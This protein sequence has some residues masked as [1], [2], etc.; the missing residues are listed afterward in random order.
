MERSVDS[1]RT[2]VGYTELV[3]RNP[4]FRNLWFG[5]IVSLFGDWFN[6]IASAA[7]ISVL[8]KSGLAVG[9]LFVVRMLAPFLVSPLAGVAADRYNRKLL[10]ILADLSRGVVVLGFLLVRDPQHAWLLYTLTAIQ[11]A[12]SGFFFPARNAI[13]PDIVSRRELGAANAL[14]SATWSVMLAVGA[15]L[16]GVVAGEWG[17]Y[18]AFII[19]SA[20][21]FISA[22]FISRIRYQHDAALSE[23][24]KSVR[25]ALTQYFN[26]LRYLK[27]HFDILSISLQKA[28][29][30]LAVNGAFQVIQVVLAE[31]IFVIGEGGGT[32]LGLLYAV[33]GVGTGI[34]PIIARRFTGDRDQPL[35]MA[36]FFSYLIAVLGLVIN[37]P[38]WN[39]PSVLLGTFLRAFGGGISWV[40]STQLLLQLLP[41]HVRGRVFSTEFALFT[42]ANAIS[43]AAGG[44]ALDNSGLSVSSLLWYM[45]GILLIPSLLWLLWLS[46]GSRKSPEP[47]VSISKGT[48]AGVSSSNQ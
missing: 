5:Q 2:T 14:S 39:F 25:A 19:D 23:A 15:A 18:P 33:G 30:A 29:F 34:G 16:G 38:L 11:L 7:L 32:S 37:A 20:T 28:A 46:F 26:G 1:Q 40:F 45:A 12:F 8:T 42:L 36:I 47:D 22:L 6:L 43:A 17:I 3:R 48:E 24:G 10:L 9:G 13:L 31:K 44:W 4:N 35:R 41:D 21:F 27:R